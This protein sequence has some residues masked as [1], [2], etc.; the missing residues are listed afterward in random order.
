MHGLVPPRALRR[1]GIEPAR[2]RFKVPD[3]GISVISSQ[4]AGFRYFG[5]LRPVRGEM[6]MA[7]K[8]RFG[9]VRVGKTLNR[10]VRA[11]RKGGK[12]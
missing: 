12:L 10:T 6:P 3:S 8:P 4:G 5:Y 11:R 7:I 1:I 9:D 2:Y